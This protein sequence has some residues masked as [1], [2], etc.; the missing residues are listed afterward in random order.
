MMK[1]PF[2]A[3][4]GLLLLSSCATDD[5]SQMPHPEDDPVFVRLSSEPVPYPKCT[6][7]DED[8]RLQQIYFRGFA[9]GWRLGL[10]SGGPG[11][12]VAPEQ[13]I[14]ADERLEDVWRE[15]QSD[16]L[17]RGM[18]RR[19]RYERASRSAIGSP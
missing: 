7:Y 18:L 17:F 5:L 8:A 12:L 11:T 6:P 13:D 9:S 1:F 14:S 15:G 16:G 3:C 2:K 19:L 10:L 4:V